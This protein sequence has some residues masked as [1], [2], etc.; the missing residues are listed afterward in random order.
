MTGQERNQRKLGP[1]DLITAVRIP[2]AVAFV[3]Q[4][5]CRKP[6]LTYDFTTCQVTCKSLRAGRA[7]RTVQRTAHL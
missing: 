3:P 2:L 7:K 4:C 1:A 6:D 5:L